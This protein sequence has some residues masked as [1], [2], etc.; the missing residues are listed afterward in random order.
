[1]FDLGCN[2]Q[3]LL[4]DIY[5]LNAMKRKSISEFSP[6]DIA[7]HAAKWSRDDLEQIKAIIEGRSLIKKG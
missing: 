3:V 4:V 6:K 5:T 1:M 7:P 2:I